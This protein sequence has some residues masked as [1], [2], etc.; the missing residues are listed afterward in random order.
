MD[1]NL[2]GD[3]AQKQVVARAEAS[4]PSKDRKPIEVDEVMNRGMKTKVQT[5]KHMLVQ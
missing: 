1:I 4:I 3:T 5:W 2:P